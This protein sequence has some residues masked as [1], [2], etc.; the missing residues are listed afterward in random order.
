[1]ISFSDK[2]EEFFYF[3]YVHLINKVQS[4]NV[5]NSNLKFYIYKGFF[6]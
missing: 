5:D 3:N 4:N 2:T 6:E 1:M